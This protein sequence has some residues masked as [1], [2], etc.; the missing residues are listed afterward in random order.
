L[1]G[2]VAAGQVIR[3]QKREAPFGILEGEEAV[4]HASLTEEPSADIFLDVESK[5]ERSEVRSSQL[6]FSST[7]WAEKQEIK[8]FARDDDV[9]ENTPYYTVVD[10]NSTSSNESLS[11]T[12]TILLPIIDADTGEQQLE[13]Y[14]NNLRENSAAE[15][16]LKACDNKLG[17]ATPRS[18][19]PD[20]TCPGYDSRKAWKPW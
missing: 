11:Q 13:D 16:F 5:D 19:S 20:P 1:Y 14:V 8:I 17:V 12:V 9:I 10:F 3:L 6:K 4:Y 15:F 7:N 18:L 2:F